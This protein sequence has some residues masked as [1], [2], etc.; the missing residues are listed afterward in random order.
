MTTIRMKYIGIIL[1]IA[2]IAFIAYLVYV[3]QGSDQPQSSIESMINAKSEAEETIAKSK[4]LDLCN[5]QTLELSESEFAPGPCLSGQIIPDWVC[6][7]AHSP[8]QEV[9]ND[10][11][12][13]CPEFKSGQAHHFIEVDVN[14]Q[15]IKSY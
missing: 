15:F 2:I 6:D 9:D 12:N 5:I 8:R 3:P 1:T 13:Q 7:V 14:C 11:A 10:P 4:C